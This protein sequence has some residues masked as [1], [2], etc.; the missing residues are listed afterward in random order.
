MRWQV[1]QTHLKKASPLVH[2][3]VGGMGVSLFDGGQP[4][5]SYIYTQ[6]RKWTVQD[7]GHELVLEFCDGSK[8]LVV[9]S[10][11]ARIIADLMGR[12]AASVA[13]ANLLA[14]PHKDL[15][16]EYKVVSVSER[17]D[18]VVL[19]GASGQLLLHCC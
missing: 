17:G 16:G 14:S 15:L 8:N 9:S 3:K 6:I 5:G 7:H 12:H 2:L 19:P 1:T 18:L 13:N 11:D 10:A 4:L